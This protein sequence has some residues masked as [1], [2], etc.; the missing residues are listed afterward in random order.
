MDLKENEIFVTCDSCK[1]VDHEPGCQGRALDC[2]DEKECKDAGKAIL[3]EST[4]S[5]QNLPSVYCPLAPGK[6]IH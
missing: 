4:P 5:G 6:V 1:R 3:S 2:K